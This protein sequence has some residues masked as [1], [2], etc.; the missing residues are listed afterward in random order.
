MPEA[1]ATLQADL[2]EAQSLAETG[3]FDAALD[4]YRRIL[5][6]DEG[7]TLAWYRKGLL[8][9]H[10]G[11]TRL[12]M[13][14]L[15]RCIS[16]S[17]TD[18][19]PRFQLAQMLWSTG[20]ARRWEALRLFTSAFELD[21]HCAEFRLNLGNALASMQM[22]GR[23]A[24]ILAP[25]PASLPSWWAAA[26]DNAIAAWRAARHEARQRL[27]ARRHADGERSTLP[28]TLRL[29]GL[30]GQIGKHRAAGSIAR[31]VMRQ[32]PHT[33]EAFAIHADVLARDTGPAAAVAFLDSIRWLFG[34]Q[35]AFE[36]AT[37]RLR[38]EVG[39]ND[40]AWRLLT[41]SLRRV[42]QESRALASSVLL[43]LNEGELL[44]E[45]C[46]EWMHDAPDDT[47]PFMFALAAQHASGRLQTFREGTGARHVDG[48]VPAAT[49]LVQF[50]D[51]PSP[52][53]EV[54]DA[55][56]SWSAMNPGL[57]HIVF[58]DASARAY[59]L[60]RYGEEAAAS[61]DW[62][63]HPAMKSDVF[64]IA[65]LASDGGIYVDADEY[66]R[67]P[68]APILHALA[69]VELVAARSADVAPYLYNAFL[70]ARPRS[71]IVRRVLE[72]L[73]AQLARA[74]RAGVRLD[75][76]HATGPGILTR[77]VSHLLMSEPD[78]CARVLLLT[79]GQYE[80][81]SEERDTM[82]YKQSTQGNWRLSDRAAP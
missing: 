54:M 73:L 24:H 48:G 53:P 82:A 18:P 78:A 72:Q 69:S 77:A 35:A 36:I 70:A 57:R 62:C 76:W 23:A 20:I 79:K 9:R 45:H 66:C 28:D 17:A 49:T 14:A 27:A 64:R 61:Y 50:W 56:S 7:C 41:P 58:D 4:A 60:D 44:L 15:R 8:H 55:M 2:A 13:V 42:S 25:L 33:W 5:D 38:Y 51:T 1:N 12:A 52:P 43:A 3:R 81:F 11:E 16:L 47:A 21:P 34:G 74:R 59:I 32:H 19:W 10:N 22:L 39:E 40:V 26:R 6:T 67:R 80:S 29:A 30:L 31:T 37:A 68:L 46:Q 71:A 63:H 75:I 65:Y